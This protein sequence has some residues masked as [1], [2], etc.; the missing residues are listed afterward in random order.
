MNGQPDVRPD[1]PSGPHFD[2]LIA[3]VRQGNNEAAKELLAEYGPHIIRVVRRRM[4][5]KLR[6]RFDSQDFTQ[7]V[8]AS[9]FGNIDE[10]T[11]LRDSEELIQ[12]LSRVA[13]NK[14]I[15]AGRRGQTS[16]ENH[17]TDGETGEQAG[18]DHR[19]NISQP[20]P[21]EH[22]MARESWDRIVQD[23]GETERRIVECRR[24]GMTQLEIATEMG[25]SERQIRRIL[26]R[27][28]RKM[29]P[30]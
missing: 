27:L 12:F 9:F 25:T 8:W 14:V 21:S 29:P 30:E 3:K 1:A 11:R 28:A 26:S 18:H 20:T 4:N 10:V 13:S 16:P 7:A 15:D 2:S 19:L 24:I 22:A 6:E 5:A 17:L 23:E